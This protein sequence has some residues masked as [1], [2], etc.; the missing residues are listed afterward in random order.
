MIEENSELSPALEWMLPGMQVSPD[1]I[2]ETLVR[3]YYP[4]LLRLAKDNQ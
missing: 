1:L 2:L 4:A 3:E